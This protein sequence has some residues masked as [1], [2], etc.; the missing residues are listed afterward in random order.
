LP[1]VWGA[2]RRLGARAELQRI[3]Q[4]PAKAPAAAQ[5]LDVGGMLGETGRAI[6]LVPGRNRI[7]R[8]AH[9]EIVIRDDTVSSEHALIE[10]VGGRYW[11][12]DLPARTARSTATSDSPAASASP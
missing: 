6:A 12:E 11:L 10:L 5:L 3:E 4:D 8:D 1:A 7:G 9:N 2:R